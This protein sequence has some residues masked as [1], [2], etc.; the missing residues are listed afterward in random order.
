MPLRSDITLNIIVHGQEV[1]RN[2]RSILRLF[3]SGNI[4]RIGRR[5][6]S[7]LMRPFLVHRRLLYF[8]IVLTRLVPIAHRFNNCHASF[9]VKIHRRRTF[10]DRL[11]II[12]VFKNLQRSATIR[13]VVRDRFILLR[14]VSS[15]LSGNSQSF[16][17]FFVHWIAR[18]LL[19]VTRG[20]LGGRTLMFVGLLSLFAFLQSRQLMNIYLRFFKEREEE[21]FTQLQH[22]NVVK[23]CKFVPLLNLGFP[24]LN[25]F[26]CRWLVFCPRRLPT[27]LSMRVPS[28]NFKGRHGTTRSIISRLNAFRQILTNVLRRRL[29]LRTCGIHLIFLCRILGLHDIILPYGE[30]QIISIKWRTCF[31]VR[32]LFRRRISP[33]SEDFSTHRVAIVGRHSIINRAI[34]RP[35]LPQHGEDAKQNRRVLCS[36]LIRQCGIH[37]SFRGRTTI[38]LCSNLLNGM[39]TM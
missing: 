38:L 12:S 6:Q 20:R 8:K 13:K 1:L 3:Y 25:R 5:R 2:V 14:I 26:K 7:R 16:I 37:V 39:S 23:N 10:K 22:Q 33:P 31:S 29:Y 28:S 35:S 34:S 30:I 18:R 24:T 4:L 9:Q 32:S 27:L 11:L 19:S 17:T 15:V 21:R 36:Q